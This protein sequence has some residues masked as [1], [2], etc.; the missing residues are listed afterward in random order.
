M[1]DAIFGMRMVTQYSLPYV[2]LSEALKLTS[3][4]EGTE[5]PFLLGRSVG[6][7]NWDFFSKL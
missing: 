1:A 7:A 5:I 4:R 2:L 3:K 6:I